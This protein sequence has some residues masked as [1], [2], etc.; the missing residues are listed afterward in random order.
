MDGSVKN[1]LQAEK[2]AAEIISRA[3][4]EMNKN[5]Q[6]AESEAQERVNIVQQDLNSRMDM[7]RRRVSGV[8]S[9]PKSNKVLSR[10]PFC[11]SSWIM[12]DK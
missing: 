1:L 3:D 2:E 9:H 6:N 4:R 12:R 7:Q 11:L 10:C 5:L 8:I